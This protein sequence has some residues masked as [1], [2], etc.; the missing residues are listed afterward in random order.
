MNKK[1]LAIGLIIVVISIILDQVTKMLALMYLKSGSIVVIEDFFNLVLHYNNGAAWSSFAG[2]F[3]FLFS[4]TIVSIIAFG[5]FFKSVNF[6][7]KLIYSLGIS[8]MLGGLFGNFIDRIFMDGHVVIDF[9]SFTFGSYR[10]PTFNIADSCLVVG[11][12]LFVIDILLLEGKRKR[13][14]V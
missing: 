9:L 3:G 2:N 6:N 7:K 14:E 8:L 13:E 4:I 1:H 11:V 12:V 10:F 5:F